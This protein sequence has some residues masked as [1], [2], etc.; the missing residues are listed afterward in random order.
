MKH[1]TAGD[2]DKYIAG[3]PPSTQLLLEQ[4]RSTIRKAAPEAGEKIGYGIP[5]FTLYGS[6]LV[7]FAGYNNHIGFYPGASGIASFQKEFSHYKSAKGSV[8]FPIGEPMP[9][10]LVTKIVQFRVKQNKERAIA[11]KLLRNCPNGHTCFK[12]SDCTTCPVCEKKSKPSEGFLSALS[13]PARRAL[14]NKGI[15]TLQKLSKCKEAD[16]LALHG[17][18]PASMPK[19]RQAL[20]EKGL[21]FKK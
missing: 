15:D 11:K 21:S 18:G 9:L 17:M 2:I 3:F 5:T 20:Q 13:A 7:H 8:Q 4:I 1:V 19:L 12:S 6:N 14:T 10:A 16:L